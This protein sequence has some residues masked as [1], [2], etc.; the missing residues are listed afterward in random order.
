MT[1]VISEEAAFDRCI[2]FLTRMIEKYGN[3]IQTTEDT[4]DTVESADSDEMIS[5]PAE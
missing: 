5:P 1:K 3:D 4:S 2:D